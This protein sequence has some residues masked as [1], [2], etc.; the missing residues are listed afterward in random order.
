MPD[1]E[2]KAFVMACDIIFRRYR[3]TEPKPCW[4]ELIKEWKTH[5]RNMG[6]KCQCSVCLNFLM[7]YGGATVLL[8]D[9]LVF[10]VVLLE[11]RT[12]KLYSLRICT[13]R[14]CNEEQ[15]PLLHKFVKQ[16]MYID[17]QQSTQAGPIHR[18]WKAMTAERIDWTELNARQ[19]YIDWRFACPK[20]GFA[21]AE[22]DV[23]LHARMHEEDVEFWMHSQSD[24]QKV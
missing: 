3:D 21:V 7:A 1:R 23:E 18:L 16:Y 24:E 6:S 4:E 8:L 13:V 12:D 22:G 19:V 10:R 5:F 17:G 11:E 15:H 14:E 9:D 20:C 2:K